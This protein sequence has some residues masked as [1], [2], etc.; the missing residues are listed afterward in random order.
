MILYLRKRYELAMPGLRP[1]AVVGIVAAAA[2]R[3]ALVAM[4]NS[5]MPMKTLLLNKSYT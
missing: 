1:A 3:S 4:W 5:R 2:I